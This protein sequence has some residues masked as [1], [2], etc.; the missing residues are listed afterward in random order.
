MTL[1]DGHVTPRCCSP[2]LTNLHAC[3]QKWDP[4]RE[5]EIHAPC[6]HRVESASHTCEC[7]GV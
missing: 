4:R 1:A 3:A 5:D 2:C 7:V 6:S